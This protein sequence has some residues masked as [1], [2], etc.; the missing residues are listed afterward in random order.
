VR[1]VTR[2]R[3]V[4]AV[5]VAAFAAAFFGIGAVSKSSP[6]S[7]GVTAAS[8]VPFAP[9][10]WTM[11]VAP[12]DPNVIVLG[13]NNGLYRSADGAKTWQPTGPR[14]VNSTSLVV[15]GRDMYLGGVPGPNPIVRNAT[16]RTA[17]SGRGVLA[18]SRDDGKTWLVLHPRGLPSVTIQALAVDPANSA[19][20]YALLNTGQLFRSS[21]GAKSFTVVSRRIGAPPW[22]LAITQ[23]GRYVAGDMDS[24]G[25]TS[26]DGKSWRRT[27]FT[28]GRGGRMVMEYAVSPGDAAHVLM[29]SVGIELSTDGGKTW[30][31]S[32][33]SSVMFGPV[34]FA[35]KT[36]TV[37]YAIGFDRSFWRSDDGGKTWRQVSAP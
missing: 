25:F 13:T 20:L 11:V 5:T 23:D 35:P 14:G 7:T 27:P 8:Q 3:A 15:S 9:W 19:N 24:G 32:L 10:Y 26:P 22:A 17:P 6:G 1:L 4:A 21:D 33:K 2:T 31:P 28:D 29:T 18:V 30:H 34:A 16:G 37:A 12:D 36:T